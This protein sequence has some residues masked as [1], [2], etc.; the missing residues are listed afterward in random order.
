MI[1]QESLDSNDTKITDIEIFTD[2]IGDEK[3]NEKI[4]SNKDIGDEKTNEKID[5]IKKVEDTSFNSK[6]TN[7]KIDATKILLLIYLYF[8]QGIPLG[9]A[10]SIPF[11]LSSNN[12]SYATQ[13]TFSFAT[14]PFSI[15]ILWAPIVDSLYIYKFGRRKSW[16]IP[17]QLLLGILLIS[18]ASSTR[19]LVSSLDTKAD[20]VFLTSIFFILNFLAATQDIVV[21]GWA[22]SMLSE[23][24]VSWQSTCNHVG[25]SLGII[26]ANT[27]FIIFESKNF[28]NKYIRP[29]FG[30]S[31]QDHG[32]VNI[33]NFM[34]VFGC[35]FML[36]TVLILV[37]KNENNSSRFWWRIDKKS[38]ESIEHRENFEKEKLNLISTYKTIYSIF[39]LIPIRKLTFILLTSKIAF[40]VSS[41]V[42]LKAV[43]AGV[44]KEM[45]TL[46]D[47]PLSLVNILW[48]LGISKFT[49][50][51][52]SL[53]YNVRMILLRILM[54]VIVAVFIYFIELFKDTDGE[55]RW[56]FYLTYFAINGI[57]GIVNTT[58]FITIV[59][60]FAKIAD[61]KIGGTYM[62]LLATL[63]NIGAMYPSTSGMYLV[64]LLTFKKCSFENTLNNL[65]N[66]INNT[67]ITTTINYSLTNLNNTLTDYK[68]YTNKCSS[69]ES[70][71]ECT[72]FGGECLV[73]IDPFYYL[74]G[75]F[76]VIGIIWVIAV[77]RFT[78]RLN[79]LPKSE[80]ALKIK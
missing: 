9:L 49:N 5:S 18:F 15:K 45:Q 55:F 43:E 60:F 23:E 63:S 24:N 44:T 53:I 52:N 10:A 62:T 61:Q 28:S 21:D 48:S 38:K 64:N 8:L 7:L 74:T 33:E 29:I 73:P 79:N 72:D 20:I 71:K 59:S 32:L 25:Q 13:G 26:V 41:V 76:S 19:K 36:T 3:M 1:N 51:K 16:L 11:L 40:T 70:T 37:F 22:I 31:N 57:M 30:A 75:V 54:N 46:F 68:N 67:N 42:F 34:I 39:T 78:R 77:T 56:Y 58:L 17:V 14:W 47:I 65:T 27:L 50:G 69:T 12:V 6:L 4:D 2:D 66:L 80:W 35:V